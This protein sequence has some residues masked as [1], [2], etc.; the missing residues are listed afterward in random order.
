VTRT[1]QPLYR[2]ATGWSE[3]DGDVAAGVGADLGLTPDAEQRW[4]LDA[5]FA[6]TDEAI[7]VH[8]EV[9]I[10][11]PRQT[12]G[13]TATLQIAALTDL[14]VLEVELAVWTAHEAKTARKTF[15]DMRRR[16]MANPDYEA[17][18]R[19][20]TAIGREA[21]VLDTGERLEFHAR[22]GSSGRGFTCQKLT[23]DE[24]LFGQPGDV[25]AL[26]P[27]LVT[28]PDAQ[29]RYASS[30]GKAVS[31]ALRDLRRRGRAGDVG[32]A[33]VEYGAPVLPCELGPR[34]PHAPMDEVPGCA[35]DNRDLW[36]QASSALWSGRL[37]LGAIEKQRRKMPPLEFMREFLS[38]WED[39]PNLTGEGDLDMLRWA[40][41]R[42]VEATPLR[43]L[44]VGVDQGEDRT[45]SIGCA[46]RRGDGGV[47][48]ML[49]HEQDVPN[50]DV[51]LSPAAAVARL[52]AL[53][54][55]W[56]ARVLLGGP[57]VGLER[58]LLDAGVPVEVVSGSEFATACGQM[59]DRIRAGTVHHGGQDELTESVAVARWRPVGT[60]GERAFQL[61]GV[62]G[63]GPAAAVV[64]ALHGVLSRAAPSGGPVAIST[65]SAASD[66]ASMQF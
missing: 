48:V 6:E 40:D 19:F 15:Q 55:R 53:R 10:V 12:V 29:T 35:L 23:L 65:S 62:P 32:L 64:R 21:I 56:S 4:L 61:R 36:W 58:E 37:T 2:T 8:D 66:V 7:P 52:V 33:Y 34:C 27:T 51:G 1:S 50:P 54:K 9:C 44:V 42:D 49:A 46:W 5:I 24:W 26:A 18:A 41:L 39:P 17:R 13:K 63:V 16:I 38:W 43:P 20:E 14:F 31:G 60:A 25:G 47:Q 30:A 45:V 59:D 11:G 3:T 22:S 28:I 57:A